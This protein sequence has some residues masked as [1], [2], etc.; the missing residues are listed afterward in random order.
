MKIRIFSN[1]KKVMTYSSI[2]MQG[3]MR[4]GNTQLEESRDGTHSGELG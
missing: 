2:T 1:E 4:L 3:V